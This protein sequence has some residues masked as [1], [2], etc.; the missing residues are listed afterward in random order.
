MIAG[1]EEKMKIRNADKN[2]RVI[3]TDIDD[4]LVKWSGNPHQPGKNKIS[5][6]DP[7]TG[8]L[9]YLTPHKKHI[10]LLKH[11]SSRGYY[12]VAWSAG[13]GLWA[14]AVIEALGINDHINFIMSKP[15]KYIDD[16]P[17][18][19][20]MGNRIYVEDRETEE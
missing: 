19:E 18:S 9:V 11:F 7:Y 16:L 15:E 6:V 12:I 5:I 13:G 2:E 8:E 4:T 20:W 10:S 1:R 3:M 17:C 14:E